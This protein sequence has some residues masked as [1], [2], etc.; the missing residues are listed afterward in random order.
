M[1]EAF[2]VDPSKHMNDLARLIIGGGD[3]FKIPDSG[4]WNSY[5]E[6]HIIIIP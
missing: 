2:L 3:G 5:L 6:F 4:L 1:T